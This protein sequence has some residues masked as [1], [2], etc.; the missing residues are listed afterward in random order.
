MKSILVVSRM[1]LFAGTEGGGVFLS[2]DE[3]RTWSPSNRGLTHRSINTLAISGVNLFA[4]AFD[5]GV[6][7]RPL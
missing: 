3:G 2:T 4:G 5:G 6:W 7:K 1:D